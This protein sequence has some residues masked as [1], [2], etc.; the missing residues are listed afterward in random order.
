[1]A[2]AGSDTE[3]IT[4]ARVLRTQGRHGEVL[5]ELHTAFPEAFAARNQLYALT[6]EGLRRALTLESFWPH[7]GGMALKFAGV[8]SID[9]AEELEGCE[10]Q[11][12]QQQRMRLE[13]GSTYV[14]DLVGCRVYATPGEDAQGASQE[15]GV[16][17]KIQF[18]AGDA[19]LLVVRSGES[20]EK[21][22]PF[23][24]AFVK[25]FDGA[26]KRLEMVLPPGLLE[27]DAPLTAE[28]KREQQRKD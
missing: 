15:V 28:E 14:S 11:I 27:L 10:I 3:F 7:K 9:Q 24:Q 4:I 22:I 1:M 19:P 25:K 13:N 23:A 12:T 8:E 6:P 17:E 20:T 16:I 18:D 5:A 26:G 2:M 21:L